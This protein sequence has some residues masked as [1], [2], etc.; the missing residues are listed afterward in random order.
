MAL[1]TLNFFSQALNRTGPCNVVIPSDKVV[2]RG[3]GRA[4]RGPY[5]T[6][7]LLRVAASFISLAATFM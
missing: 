6:L 7:Y 2:A 1:I 3:E 4:Q 5:K